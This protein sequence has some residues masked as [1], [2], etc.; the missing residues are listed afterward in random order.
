MTSLNVI[1][2]LGL[3]QIYKTPSFA[4]CSALR[5][6]LCKEGQLRPVLAVGGTGRILRLKA[7]TS[8]DPRSEPTII[9]VEKHPVY[10][11]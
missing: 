3:R 11:L 2:L 1:P 6:S 9:D 8:P 4:V 7:K 5:H 10:S